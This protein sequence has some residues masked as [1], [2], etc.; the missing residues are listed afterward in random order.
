MEVIIKG[1]RLVLTILT[2]YIPLR[3]EVQTPRKVRGLL[4]KQTHYAKGPRTFL[5]WGLY[6]C[7]QEV[8]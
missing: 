1:Y 5:G 2:L 3:Y 8:E 4:A 6:V 7:L